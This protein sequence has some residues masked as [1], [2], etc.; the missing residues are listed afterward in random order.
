MSFEN[1]PERQKADSC[2]RKIFRNL[3]RSLNFD[4]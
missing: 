2:V 4:L 3:G 1:F